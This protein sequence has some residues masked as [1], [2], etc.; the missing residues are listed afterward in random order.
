MS[1]SESRRGRRGTREEILEKWIT[2]RKK[3]EE[4]EKD[5]RKARKTIKKLEEENPWLGNILGIIRKGE[6][7]GGGSP[8]EEIP[9]GSDGGRLRD[10]EEASQERV[11]RQGEGGSPQKE[12]PREQEEAALLGRK[13]P[14]QGGRRG[15]RKVDR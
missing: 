6:G 2:T 1:Q 10:W 15:T 5:L 13:E 14:Q 12:G 4:F 11:H 7:R 3:A 8:G 9:D